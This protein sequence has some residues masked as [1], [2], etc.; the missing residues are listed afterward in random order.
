M[1]PYFDQVPNDR[2]ESCLEAVRN[3]LTDFE[4][5]GLHYRTEDLRWRHIGMC[6]GLVHIFD[7]GSLEERNETNIDVDTSMSMLQKKIDK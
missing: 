3:H 7:L 6:N 5:L 2:R 4:A 1:I